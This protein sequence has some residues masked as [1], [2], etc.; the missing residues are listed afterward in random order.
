MSRPLKI[1]FA[2]TEL[3]GLGARRGTIAVLIAPDGKPD[4]AA[5]K[6]SRVTRK[7]LD[8]LTESDRFT[9]LAAGEAI[10]VDFPTGIAAERVVVAKLA[11][12]SDAQTARVAGAA[13]AELWV[14][15][16]MT[17]CAG[18]LPTAAD[19]ALGLVLKSYRFTRYKTDALPA[20]SSAT[21][22]VDDTDAAATAYQSLS[23]QAEGV[24]FA[25]DLVNEPANVLT[26]EEFAH[27][28]SALAEL[29]VEIEILDE[30]ALRNLGMGLLLSVAQGSSSPAKAVVMTWR[31]TTDTPP[32]ALVGKGVVFDSGGISIKG[33][34]GMEEMTAD[35]GGAGTVAGVMRCLAVRKAK[36]HV[37]GIVGLVENM[38][39]GTATRPG[40]IV[41][42]MKG[43]TV[44]IINTDAE[45]RLVLADLLWFAQTRFAPRAIVDLA[46]LTGAIT[47]A[48]G[49]EH[50]GAFS[51]DDAL[52]NQVLAACASTGEP[53][54]RM[55]LAPGHVAKIASRKADI[56]N[57]GPREGG[58]CIAAGFLQR[59]IKPDQPWLHLDIAGTANVSEATP[60]APKGATGWGVRALDHWISGLE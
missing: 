18:D 32:V 45:G 36:A 1:D 50:S 21:V 5:R 53:A 38:P 54:W 30:P 27:R 20:R 40:D 34:A 42:S 11:A 29:G 51:N 35:M 17:L 58:A 7:A 52:V 8:R 44:E 16:D 3:E 4:R 43:D 9:A 28:L 13:I 56:K 22:L 33:R 23:A 6:L 55:P 59:F 46:T 15:G 41:T 48:L 60:F 57:S 25:R 24:Y 2:K 19:L 37:V 14:G 26:C 12:D 31:G 39:S 47:V 10:A 49:S